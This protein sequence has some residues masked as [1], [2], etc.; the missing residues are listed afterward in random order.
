MEVKPRRGSL[1]ALL[2][3]RLQSLAS[4]RAWNQLPERSPRL[5]AVT[6]KVG[7]RFPALTLGGATDCTG[8]R[9]LALSLLRVVRFQAQTGTW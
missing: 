1:Q 9:P 3:T 7:S 4:S 8:R 2:P 6:A 5:P